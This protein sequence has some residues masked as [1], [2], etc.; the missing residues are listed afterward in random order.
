MSRDEQRC[1]I[2]AVIDAWWIRKVAADGWPMT[3]SIR[4]ETMR[5]AEAMLATGY[6]II[7]IEQKA[8]TDLLEVCYGFVYVARMKSLA[9]QVDA[10]F[11]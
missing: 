8:I 10:I 9:A 4:D 3:A 6:V 1:F 2:Q 5:K 11:A 7:D